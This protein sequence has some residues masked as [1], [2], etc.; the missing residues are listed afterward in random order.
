MFFLIK[1]IFLKMIRCDK[2]IKH[3]AIKQA[4]KSE[5]RWGFT[6]LNLFVKLTKPSAAKNS[7]IFAGSVSCLV[8]LTDDFDAALLGSGFPI[9]VFV[10]EDIQRRLLHTLSHRPASNTQS[11]TV[12]FT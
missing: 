12:I 9:L 2:A 4:I 7:S 5:Q 3:K 11:I 1:T 10:N 8:D 6:C